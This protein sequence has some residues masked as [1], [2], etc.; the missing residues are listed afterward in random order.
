MIVGIDASRAFV[1][2]RTGIE[3]YSYQIIKNLRGELKDRQVVLY[4]RPGGDE[5]VDFDLPKKW[6]IKILP[7]KYLW[8]QLALSLELLINPVD[9]LLVPA[10]TI[11]LI[12]PKRSFVV[13]H[14]LEYEFS[15]ESY[16]WRSRLFH[17]F[18]IKKSCR[19]A[20]KIIA[21]SEKTKNDLINL[22]NIK[23]GKIIVIGN[24]FNLEAS[25]NYKT[26]KVKYKN[27]LFF[28][29]RLEERKNITGIIKAFN[30]FKNKYNYKGKLLLAGGQGYGYDKIKQAI[31]QSKFKSDIVE[32]GFIDERKKW[33][34]LKQADIFIY[35]SLF[36]GFGIPIL[37]AQSVGTPVITS[38]RSPTKEVA[39]DQRILVNPEKP[40]KIAKLAN[41]ILKDRELHTDITEQGL[42]N[43]RK[44]SWKK[45][46][47][48]IGKLLQN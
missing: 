29:G 9:I 23:S 40:N 13:V 38:D 27:F 10:H 8:T 41:K 16:S 3:E 14:G 11:P 45:S 25:Q 42:K 33:S 48:K 34:Y 37:E 21:V 28:I 18:F 44:Y 1:K 26:L 5:Q 47:D 24:G 35:P 20:R 46:A 32:L 12:H 31:N 43:I 15:P 6:Q 22:Y 36:E 17:K 2:E 39:G 19:W 7:W 4:T 30:I